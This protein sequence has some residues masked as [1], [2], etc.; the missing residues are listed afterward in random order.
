MQLLAIL[1]SLFVAT[2]TASQLKWDPHYD[3]S[4]SLPLDTVSCSDGQAGFLTKYQGQ[5]Q[6]TQQLR[7]K[8]NPNIYFAAAD[9]LWNSPNCGKCW[10]IVGTQTGVTAYFVVIDN[11]VPDIVGGSDLF[12]QL[13]P[14]GNTGL[15]IIEVYV[16]EEPDSTCFK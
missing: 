3:S 15:G 9:A 5:I 14:D 2:A 4:Y 7:T 10:K 16:Y 6:N 12:Q 13:A 8:L 1:T 11:A